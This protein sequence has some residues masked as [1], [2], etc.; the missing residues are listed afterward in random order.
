VGIE[1]QEKIRAGRVLIIGAGGLGA[2]AALYLAAAGVGTLGIVDG[3]KVE[4]SNLQ[5]QIIHS[6]DDI[7]VAKVKSAAKKIH[8]L[9]PDVE[10]KIYP[11]ILCAANARDIL[12][13]Y[14]F[15][16]DGT[17]NFAAK[18][19]I[20]DACVLMG[21]PFSHGGILR[22]KGQTLTVLPGQSAC[23]RCVFHAAPPTNAVPTCS[24][25]G[26]LGAVAGMLGTIQA[27]ECLKFLTKVGEL[28]KDRILTF[29]AKTMEFRNVKIS[30]RP[31]CPV[32]GANPSIRELRDEA[33]T[34]CGMTRPS[35]AGGSKGTDDSNPETG[36]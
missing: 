6:T 17:D 33:Q 8:R 15:A 28:I 29:D 14:D 7:G 24:Q 22:F 11:E 10:V 16:I 19:L 2:P 23:Y 18:F 12:S 21:V 35:T 32:C 31:E 13:G 1:G 25:A 20:N 4:L 3:D 36:G 27:A 34:A 30:R 9:N 26:V 5:R